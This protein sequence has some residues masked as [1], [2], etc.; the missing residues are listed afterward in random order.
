MSNE[1]CQWVA[2]QFYSTGDVS[3]LLALSVY[4]AE[5]GHDMTNIT[6]YLKV[7]LGAKS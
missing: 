4:M 6:Y 7:K 5:Q 1:K 3:G 2:G